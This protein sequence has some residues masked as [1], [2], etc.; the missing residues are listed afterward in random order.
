M[1]GLFAKGDN[2]D[3]VFYRRRQPDSPATLVLDSAAP[4]WEGAIPAL[5]A[6]LDRTTPSSTATIKVPASLQGRLVRFEFTAASP[7]VEAL[8]IRL[9]FQKGGQEIE[10]TEYLLKPYLY[11]GGGKEFFALPIPAQADTCHVQLKMSKSAKDVT[12]TSFRAL[13]ETAK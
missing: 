10:D 13:V 5:P 7:Q 4:A 2:P 6:R 11:P 12:F 9:H 8:T 1:T 3:L